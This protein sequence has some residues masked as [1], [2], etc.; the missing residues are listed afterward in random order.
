[1]FVGQG[2]GAEED[3]KGRPFQ[4]PA[5]KLLRTKVKPVLEANQL[6]IILDNTIRARPL[7]EKGKNR[8]PTNK[9]LEFCKEILWER[10][11]E[12]K[13]NVIIP[14]GAS[15]TGTLIPRLEKVAI[16]RVRGVSVQ[17]NGHTFLPTFHP[18]AILHAQETETKLMLEKHM[19][20]DIT[21]AVKLAN[22]TR[23][24]I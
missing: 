7:D 4:G 23:N 17:L 16:S 10:I 14:L 13:P 21:Q 20:E 15:A 5:G 3:Q 8:A 19:V 6:N 2:A 12:F 1:M 9:E 24:L 18:A 22:Q 11:E